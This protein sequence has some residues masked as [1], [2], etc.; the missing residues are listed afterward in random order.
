MRKKIE[1]EERE[2]KLPLDLIIVFIYL[3]RKKISKRCH[4]YISEINL[5]HSHLYGLF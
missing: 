3:S 5:G 4:F 2:E 1:K